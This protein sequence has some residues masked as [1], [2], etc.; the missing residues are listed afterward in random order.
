[1]V[2][3]LVAVGAADFAAQPPHFRHHPRHEHMMPPAGAPRP[4]WLYPEHKLPHDREHVPGPRPG[5]FAHPPRMAGAP[6][7]MPHHHHHGAHPPMMQHGHGPHGKVMPPTHAPHMHPRHHE[8][9]APA[10]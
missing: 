10:Y 1:M 7:D 9:M 8:P 5:P 6:D 4:H 2:L 3:G